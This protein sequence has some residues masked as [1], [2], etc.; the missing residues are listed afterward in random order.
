MIYWASHG[1]ATHANAGRL[2]A[3]S[4]LRR[5]TIQ[6]WPQMV[7]SGKRSHRCD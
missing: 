7:L 2:R 3:M 5:K 1:A 6:K 4:H